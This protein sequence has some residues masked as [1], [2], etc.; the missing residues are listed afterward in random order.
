MSAEELKMTT[1]ESMAQ[2]A[3]QLSEALDSLG[4]A[5]D[6]LRRA[7]RHHDAEH[8]RTLGRDIREDWY[9]LLKHVPP[10]SPPSTLRHVYVAG[11]LSQGD[12]LANI[13]NA[14][15]SGETLR[16]AGLVPF[17]P[18]LFSF[19]HLLSPG[20]YESWMALDFAWLERCDALVRLPGLSSGSDR[21]VQRAS[22]LGLPVYYSVQE[23]IAAER[24]RGL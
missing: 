11:P 20:A 23:C 9:A 22:A 19:W 1:E 7:G 18:H 5:G 12:Q 8:L 24:Q 17:V 21:E 10:A 6:S 15:L 2:A 13:R 4:S 16:K 3:R 14:I